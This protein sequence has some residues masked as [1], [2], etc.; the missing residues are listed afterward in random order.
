MDFGEVKGKLDSLI[1]LI[2]RHLEDDK[3]SFNEIHSR[4][5][6]VERKVYWFSG[7]W[8]AVGAGISFLIG[9]H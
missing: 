4:L 8:A 6:K 7:A 3:A 5:G 2:T 9:R 1:D